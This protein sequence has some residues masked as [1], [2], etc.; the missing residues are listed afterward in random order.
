MS[1]E[2]RLPFAHA[3]SRKDQGAQ[4][5]RL[6]AAFHARLLHPAGTGLSLPDETGKKLSRHR[7]VPASAK[8]KSVECAPAKRRAGR[9]RQL[10]PAR[11]ESLR[12]DTFLPAVQRILYSSLSRTPH[13]AKD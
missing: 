9:H 12:F 8:G 1:A 10:N 4:R 3:V 13:F 6:H 2:P 11:R 7:F 5:V